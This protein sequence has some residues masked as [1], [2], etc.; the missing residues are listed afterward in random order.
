[1]K[2]EKK[3]K[4]KKA[5][6]RFLELLVSASGT[7]P[8]VP[9]QGPTGGADKTNKPISQSVSVFL[10]APSQMHFVPNSKSLLR[11]EMSVGKIRVFFGS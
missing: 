7:F 6:A 5:Q 8:D 2:V 11:D 4:N 9:V 3:Q 1:M 10:F